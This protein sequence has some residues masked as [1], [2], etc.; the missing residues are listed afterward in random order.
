MALFEKTSFALA[1]LSLVLLTGCA[2]TQSGNTELEDQ[3][4]A[5]QRWNDCI[6][7]NT[8]SQNL[9]AVKISQLLNHSCEG[10]KRDVIDSF[11][12]HMSKQIDQLLVSRLYKLLT[13]QNDLTAL[14]PAETML[15]KTALR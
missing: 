8:Q 5:M 13:D 15:I 9:T 4:L 1:V 11:P 14:E 3:Q 7:R 12:P 2:T 10:H 6:D